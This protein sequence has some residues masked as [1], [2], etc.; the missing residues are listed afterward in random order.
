M[1]F[2]KLSM[3]SPLMLVF[4]CSSELAPQTDNAFIIDTTNLPKKI[5]GISFFTTVDCAGAA[6]SLV[7]KYFLTPSSPIDVQKMETIRS[8]AVVASIDRKPANLPVVEMNSI[9]RDQADSFS[10]GHRNA[11]DYLNAQCRKLTLNI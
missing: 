11:E 5:D 1:S 9:I 4:A 10:K 7:N 2:K 8:R 3:L 6:S